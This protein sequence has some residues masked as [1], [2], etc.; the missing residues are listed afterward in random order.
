MKRLAFLVLLLSL[1]TG[2]LTQ[3]ASTDTDSAGTGIEASP[4][5]QQQTTVQRT[6]SVQEMHKSARS[7]SGL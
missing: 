3:C 6:Q 7:Q 5:Y 2:L 1:S 4:V